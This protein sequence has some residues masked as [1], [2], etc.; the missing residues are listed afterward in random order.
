MPELPEVQTTVEGLKTTIVGHAIENVRVVGNSQKI[1]R[2]HDHGA[3]SAIVVGA[4][5]TN[6]SRRAKNIVLDLSNVHTIVI[7]MRMSGHLLVTSDKQRVTS[8][9]KWEGVAKTD[10]LGDPK[11]QFIRV[12]FGLSG[13]KQL[14]FSDLRK[15]GTIDVYKTDAAK[16]HLQEK[17]GPEP[18][19]KKL[20][21]ERFLQMLKSKK[22]AI[23]PLIMDQSFI[24]G[25]GNIYA[26][27][28]LWRAKIHPLTPANLLASAQAKALLEAIRTVLKKG[29]TLGGTSID[30]YR[31]PNGQ[32]GRFGEV[33][34]AYSRHGQ[35][36]PRCGTI[37]QRI[38]VGQRGTTFCPHCQ[39]RP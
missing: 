19:D 16:K 32:K 12:I 37:M 31:Q 20:T 3:F 28:S 15:F 18:F 17:Y 9:G 39:K 26:D 25:V 34:K 7:H 22:T 29:I 21:S 36:C 5:I 30:D 33:L 1:L 8:D 11:N 13:G 23:K 2:S 10:P 24:A 4:K 27:E 6:V 35:P 14:A 38:V